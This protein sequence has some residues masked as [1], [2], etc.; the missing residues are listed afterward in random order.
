MFIRS[1]NRT[2]PHFHTTDDI[3]YSTCTSRRILHR[4]RESTSLFRSKRIRDRVRYVAFS[5]LLLKRDDASQYSNWLC[6]SSL[7]LFIFP[8]IVCLSF[9]FTY[10]YLFVSF[11]LCML[12]LHVFLFFRAVRVSFVFLLQECIIVYC[13]ICI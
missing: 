13:N 8:C 3:S 4:T 2:H 10:F 5:M 11:F 7:G 6:H 9:L 12:F 1:N